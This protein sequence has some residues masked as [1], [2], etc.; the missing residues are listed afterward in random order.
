MSFDS[1]TVISKLPGKP[2]E[3]L[4]AER[5]LSKET[6]EKIAFY[7]SQ[8]AN[9]NTVGLRLLQILFRHFREISIPD[10]YVLREVQLRLVEFKKNGGSWSICLPTNNPASDEEMG[11]CDPVEGNNS[12]LPN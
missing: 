6:K 3:T 7:V 10:I 12:G 9:A 11:G 8:I 2:S 5:N 4:T 1:Q